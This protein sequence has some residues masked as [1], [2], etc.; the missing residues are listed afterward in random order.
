MMLAGGPVM[1]LLLLGGVVALMLFLYKSFQFHR[2]E[3]NV[4]EL[5]TGLTNV[6]DRDGYVEAIT[7]CD[8]TPGP[9][10]KVL[11]SV[12]L[13]ARGGDNDLNRAVED[14]GLDEVPK[15]ESML[16]LLEAIGYLAPLLG[17]LGTVLGMMNAFFQ[18]GGTQTSLISQDKLIPGVTMALMTTAAGLTL[19]ICC[20]AAYTYLYNRVRHLVLDMERGASE[21]VA[22]LERRRNEK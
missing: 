5:I 15:L 9:A 4:R 3:V 1:W 19:A 20:Y 7:L 11:A 10:A 6:L 22:Y 8:N 17:L 13:A 16:S 14:A 2:D 18:L 12:I 21:M